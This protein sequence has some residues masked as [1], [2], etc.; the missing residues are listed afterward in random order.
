MLK[1]MLI[2]LYFLS[3]MHSHFTLHPSH[4]SRP[5]SPPACLLENKIWCGIELFAIP[6]PFEFRNVIPT[7]EALFTPET[8]TSTQKLIPTLES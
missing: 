8:T 2:A 5:I 4:G 3:N 6:H 7:L 1:N